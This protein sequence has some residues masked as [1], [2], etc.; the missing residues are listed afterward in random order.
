MSKAILSKL[1]TAR[2]ITSNIK[3]KVGWVYQLKV[4][5]CNNCSLFLK[6]LIGCFSSVFCQ[7]TIIPKRRQLASTHHVY[8]LPRSSFICWQS[9]LSV[10]KQRWKT[11]RNIR[12]GIKSYDNSILN[13]EK[14]IIKNQE[15]I[16]S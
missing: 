12:K 13:L 2:Y 6:Y 4:Y 8:S 15:F 9:R 3:C 1:I 16:F 14:D 10:I 11:W 5:K 7:A